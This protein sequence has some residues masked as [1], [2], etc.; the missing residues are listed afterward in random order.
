MFPR[1]D[2]ILSGNMIGTKGE[3]LPSKAQTLNF[4]LTARDNKMGG[5]GVCYAATQVT[6]TSTG[7]FNVT[8]PNASNI[9]W[10]EGSLQTVT[11]N[12]GGTTASPVSCANV[13]IYLSTDGGN[14]FK[15]LAM[16]V[17]NDGS[18]TINVPLTGATITT[19]RIKIVCPSNIFFDIN[20]INFTITKTATGIKE[21]SASNGISL[22]IIPNPVRGQVEIN[23][24]G[25]NNQEKVIL[26]I[27]DILGN[28][29]K[30]EE[31]SS[32]QNLTLQYDFS[33]LSNGVYIIHLNNGD[34]R[35]IARMVKE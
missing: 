7:P 8:Y 28:R 20:D 11:W 23:A 15:P 1:L 26:A 16:N 4:R 33:Y 24:Y 31:I 34:K 13:D 14:T 35:S 10:Q 12:V 25:L 2:V 3:Y 17:P 5:G 29:I 30:A 21:F 22:H 32:S 18:E 9:S 6:I 27:Y 19:C